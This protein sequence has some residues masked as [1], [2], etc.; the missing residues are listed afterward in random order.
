MA[1]SLYT[2]TRPSGDKRAATGLGFKRWP[3][4][5]CLGFRSQRC[6][7]SRH[8]NVDFLNSRPTKGNKDV[9]RMEVTADNTA[10]TASGHF[11]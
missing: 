7:K 6:F 8:K 1:V 2:N 9:G 3:G 10:T 5:A 11:F 4:E